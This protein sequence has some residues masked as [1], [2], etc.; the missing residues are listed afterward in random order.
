MGVPDP[1]TFA[2]GVGSN[3]IPGQGYPGVAPLQTWMG[4]PPHGQF[5]TWGNSWQGLLPDLAQLLPPSKTDERGYTH[6]HMGEAP[7]PSCPWAPL[8]NLLHV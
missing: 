6:V 3:I 2:D 8:L 7:P 1:R 5:W 4:Y